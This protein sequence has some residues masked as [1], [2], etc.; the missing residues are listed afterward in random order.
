VAD[1]ERGNEIRAEIA[2]LERLVA[3]YRTNA[4]REGSAASA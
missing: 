1:T 3:A 2:L 4:L